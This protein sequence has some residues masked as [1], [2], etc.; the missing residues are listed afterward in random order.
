MCMSMGSAKFVFPHLTH[1]HISRGESR[2]CN[3]LRRSIFLVFRNAFGGIM[4]IFRVS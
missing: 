2:A 3:L 1:L 4:L